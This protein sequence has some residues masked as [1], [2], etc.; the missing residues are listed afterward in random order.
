[1]HRSKQRRY[2]ITSSAATSMPGGTLMPS[3]LAVFEIDR[4]F[5]LYRRLHGSPRG[6]SPRR[7]LQRSATTIRSRT[8]NQRAAADLICDSNAVPVATFSIH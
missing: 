7:K 3:I 6:L 5:E 4:E 2:S 1:M 8:W